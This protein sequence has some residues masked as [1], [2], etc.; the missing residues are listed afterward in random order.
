MKIK[1]RKC[2][3]RRIVQPAAILVLVF[4]VAWSAVAFGQTRRESVDLIISGATVVTMDAKRGVYEDGSVAVKGDSIVE[5]GP[6]TQIESRFRALQTID[7]KG[8]LL[9]PGF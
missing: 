3:Q 5:V 8:R 9:L 4:T 6:R 2:H 7:G 1:K